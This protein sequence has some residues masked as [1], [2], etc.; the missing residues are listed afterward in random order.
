[1]GEKR[2]IIYNC[3]FCSKKF[4][5]QDLVIH[6]DKKHQDMIPENYTALRVVF[7]YVNKKPAGYNGKCVICGN[8]T[9]W[10]ENKGRYNR[11][12]GSQKCHDEYVK[13]FE[14]NM[15]NSKGVKRI[16]STTEGQV[17]ML[18]NRK[19]SGEYKFQDGGK[20]TYTGSY[21]KKCLEFM[22]KVL[23]CKSEDVVTPGPI[24]YY[25]Y[26]GKKHVYITDIYYAPYDLVI[27][28]KDGGDNPNNRNMPEYRAKQIA[29]EKTIIDETKYNYLRLTNN[30]FSQ[31]M[32]TFAELKMNMV[33]NN[34]VRVI[35]INEEYINESKDASTIEDDFKKK[36]G[37]SFKL[38]DLNTKEA[39]KYVSD[40]WRNNKE[41]RLAICKEDNKLAGY[42]YWNKSS[43]TIGPINIY[44]DYRGYGLSKILIK[45]SIKNGGYILGVYSDNKIAIK[46]YK[47]LGFIEVE[48]KIY[49][50][51]DI[52]IIMILKSK[53][54][55][56]KK[57]I[58]EAMTA[59]LT[60][61]I[62]GSV[63]NPNNTYV[64]NYMQNN[65]FSGYGVSDNIKLTNIVTRNPENGLLSRVHKDFLKDKKYKV[66]QLD[67]SVEEVNNLLKDYI[68][69]PVEENFL[70]ETLTGKTLYTY[71][72]IKFDPLLH[73]SINY[74]E[75]M[76]EFSKIC[77]NYFSS[78]ESKID[79]YNPE[80]GLLE[81]Y[82]TLN[83]GLSA[84]VKD[85]NSKNKVLE[86]LKYLIKE[87]Q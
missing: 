69:G 83:N 32:S 71:D 4:N 54:K 49:K 80:T 58:S 26:E 81:F 45:E 18:A 67:K 41:C 70:Y 5:R 86:N 47:D 77:D 85:I 52:V 59:L 57:S 51:G 82:Q 2:I 74:D 56:Y 29:K 38:I 14:N 25:M 21:E 33:D 12:C 66:Y 87:D 1:M 7:D 9:G 84:E 35:N 61:Y 23:G 27:E 3:P 31:L 64:V 13:R 53:L 34:K 73:E 37:K 46:V 72:Q 36:S 19:I 68:G 22:D 43:G 48:K 75:Y 62:P 15:M 42:I 30:N 55:K 24:L 17:K 78:K 76:D 40:K 50:N 20:R 16:S 63:D 28:V 10:D 44:K 6:V 11:L 65:V 39:L 60:G 8:E 79:S